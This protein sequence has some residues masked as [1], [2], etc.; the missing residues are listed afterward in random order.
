MKEV[1]SLIGL[2]AVIVLSLFAIIKWLIGIEK[3]H[4]FRKR[5]RV[6]QYSGRAVIGGEGFLPSDV[7][8]AYSSWAESLGERGE[9]RVSYFLAD[10]PFEDYWVFNDILIR[11]GNYTT[12]VDHII[13]SRFGVFVLET[14]NLHGKIYG[15]ENREYWSQYLPDWGYKRFGSIQ[16]HKV[17]NPIWQNNGHIKSLRRLVFGNDIPIYGIVVF[18]YETNLYVDTEHPVLNMRDVVPYIKGFLK[19]SLSLEQMDLYKKRLLEVASKYESDRK[20]HL[21]NIRRNQERRDAALASGKCPLCGGQ[22]VLREGK[23]GRFFGC[24]NYPQCKYTHSV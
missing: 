14:K 23:H 18:P 21:D 19:E 9:R 3:R 15:S 22:L 6:N 10:L 5:N 11:Y 2:V 17:R 7:T 24:S 13:I 1:I 8:V 4:R 12:Q 20:Y 16:E